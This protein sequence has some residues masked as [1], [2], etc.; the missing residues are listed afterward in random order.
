MSYHL[1]RVAA[2]RLL[3]QQKE[4]IRRHQNRLDFNRAKIDHSFKVDLVEDCIENTD[5]S[6]F[7]YKRLRI[8]CRTRFGVT[9]TQYGDITIRSHLHSGN[10]TELDKINVGFG[11]YMLYCWGTR[12]KIEEYIIIDLDE[13]RE[14]QKQFVTVVD[15]WNTDGSSA[16]NCYSIDRIVRTACCIVAELKQAA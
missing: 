8:A 11:D 13:F 14:R 5:L 10:K 9:S 4:I 12:D 7:E 2:D 3:G 15:K 6:F 1:N 16:F